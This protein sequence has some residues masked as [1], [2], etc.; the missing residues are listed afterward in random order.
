MNVPP[1]KILKIFIFLSLFFF[2]RW[3]GEWQSLDIYSQDYPWT[4]NLAAS[5][6]QL[7]AFQA[8]TTLSCINRPLNVVFI[9]YLLSKGS[10]RHMLHTYRKSP[11]RENRW[12][13][14]DR[15]S[16]WKRVKFYHYVITTRYSQKNLGIRTA[17]ARD[18][19]RTTCTSPWK[20]HSQHTC[21]M[22]QLTTWATSIQ[23]FTEEKKGRHGLCTISRPLKLRVR[24][25]FLRK[26]DKNSFLE[27][28][29]E[30]CSVRYLQIFIF[31]FYLYD[32]N[33]APTSPIWGSKNLPLGKSFLGS[34]ILLG[35]KH[36]SWPVS[37]RRLS[38]VWRQG[39]K[40]PI[41]T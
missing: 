9:S 20:R 21:K 3:V 32:S 22:K 33:R 18:L 28:V 30:L 16:S 34:K 8:Y 19:T 25:S 27:K 15:V 39:G 10:V 12:W 31:A 37:G 38:F 41:I 17:Q 7:L 36:N 1:G 5:A 24:K 40:G 13:F 23:T 11:D 29:V 14:I 2:W 4:H 35:K 6:S 26:V